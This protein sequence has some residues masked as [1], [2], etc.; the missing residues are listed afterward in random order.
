MKRVAIAGESFSTNVGDRAIHGCLCYLLK[1]LDPTI[2]AISID[3]SG[4]IPVT[5]GD[6][7]LHS[8]QR[9][10]LLSSA[11]GFR[12][13]IMLMKI[14]HH[15]L[16]IL[17]GQ[18]DKV[19]ENL[20]TADL[21]IIGGGQLL[22]D[23]GLNFP[24]KLSTLTRQAQSL[25]LPYHFSA[26]GVGQA[27]SHLGGTLFRRMLAN[28]QSIT[29]RDHLSQDRLSH[30]VPGIESSVTFDP[31]IWAASVYPVRSSHQTDVRIGL[32]VLNQS[33]GNLHLPQKK[34][35]S[36]RAWT[37]MWMDLL[38]KLAVDNYPVEI[39]T[40]GSPADYVFA[41]ELFA[42]AQNEGWQ[43]VSLA[44]FPDSPETLL[45]A[46]S[47]YSVVV[48]ARLHAAVLANACGVSSVGLAWDQ[49]VKAYYAETGRS[50]LCFNLMDFA[51]DEAAN[52]C[53]AL[54]GQPYPVTEL[55]KLKMRALESVRVILDLD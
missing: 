39:F 40:T 30:L 23:D 44:P 45:A 10:A 53:A 8:K 34:R 36:K 26:C 52:V 33:E 51:P 43:M 37:D 1:Q 7:R 55:E 32:G 3:I 29:L 24:L 47:G 14:A 50:D 15:Q 25:N 18:F 9:M 5:R 22:M 2:E 4:R 12:L 38:G 13:P 48:A 41:R 42:V 54:T 20:E 46:L 16:K 31:A 21:L 35:F 27:W 6:S 11:P 17:Q 19:Q 49:K 28:A